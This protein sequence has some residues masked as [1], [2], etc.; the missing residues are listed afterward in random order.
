[1]SELK[2]ADCTCWIDSSGLPMVIGWNTDKGTG[3]LDL[4]GAQDFFRR[5]DRVPFKER[6]GF[7]GDEQVLSFWPIFKR[8]HEGIARARHRTPKHQAVTGLSQI[9]PQLHRR[10]EWNTSGL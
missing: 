1:V 5:T 8:P 10:V 4:N 9:S 6:I 3:S 7:P 2:C